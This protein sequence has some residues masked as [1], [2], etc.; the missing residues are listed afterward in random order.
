MLCSSNHETWNPLVIIRCR[1]E[2]SFYI[3]AMWWRDTML[4]SGQTR[5]LIGCRRLQKCEHSD[6]WNYIKMLQTQHTY[7]KATGLFALILNLIS[8]DDKNIYGIFSK[9][10]PAKNQFS[11]IF[12]RQQFFQPIHL[13]HEAHFD[14][15]SISRFLCTSPLDCLLIP[16]RVQRFPFI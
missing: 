15:D 14:S 8:H 13:I 12:S 4:L 10:V 16:F 11:N 7:S 6:N 5:F 3:I 9:E 2:K 1:F